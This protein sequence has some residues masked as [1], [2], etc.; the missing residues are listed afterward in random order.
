MTDDTKYKTYKNED[1]TIDVVSVYG[2]V[3]ATCKD[4]N[5][6]NYFLKSITNKAY[7]ILINNTRSNGR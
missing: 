6:V 3:L 7:S 2:Q 5:G 1:G 4:Q